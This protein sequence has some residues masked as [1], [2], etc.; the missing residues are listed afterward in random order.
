[1]LHEACATDADAIDNFL[2]PH[3]ET[4]MFLRGNLASQGA[5]WTDHRHSTRF[6][7]WS[8]GGIA[9]VFGLSKE[10]FLMCQLP[11]GERNACRAFAR[12]ISGSRVVGMTGAVDQVH[13]LLSVLGLADAGF[14]LL[15]D[16]PLYHLSLKDLPVNIQASRA[17]LQ[18]DVELLTGWLKHYMLETQVA[19]SEAEALD[20]AIMRAKAAPGSSMRLLLRDGRP[21]AMAALNAKV[22]GFVQV[23][24]VYV[25]RE[26]RNQGLGR[27]MTTALLSDA[28][29]DGAREAILFA[30]SESAARVYEAVGFNKIGSYRLALLANSTEIG[31]LQTAL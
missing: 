8:D 5:G 19:Q 28:L 21:V 7:I 25:P 14:S 10:G 31:S 6:W 17:A 4:S 1:M 24:G 23:G 20:R 3:T 11:G 13:L 12:A 18:S 26:L 2:K 16:E 30:A 22:D 15:R 29:A 9:G 27:K